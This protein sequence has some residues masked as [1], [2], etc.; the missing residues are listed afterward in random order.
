M[1]CKCTRYKNNFDLPF[2]R[3]V[4]SSGTLPP[5]FVTTFQNHYSNV[6]SSFS[7]VYWQL[8][9]SFVTQGHEFPEKGTTAIYEEL[10]EAVAIALFFRK[11]GDMMS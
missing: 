1:L 5:I 7:K 3:K 4:S 9:K 8:Q 11:A 2:T 10:K 6:S